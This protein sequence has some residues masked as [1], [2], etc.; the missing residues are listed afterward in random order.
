[1]ARYLCEELSHLVPVECWGTLSDDNFEFAAPG[2]DLLQEMLDSDTVIR[3]ED[4]LVGMY[5]LHRLY[6]V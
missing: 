3:C 1:M 5:V 4:H 6:G 2:R